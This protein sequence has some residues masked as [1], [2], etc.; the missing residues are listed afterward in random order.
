MRNEFNKMKKQG[1]LS[2]KMSDQLFYNNI[3]IPKTMYT[4]KHKKNVVKTK[5]E[6]QEENCSH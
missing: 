5:K 1:K 4:Y 6:I 3:C 2:K